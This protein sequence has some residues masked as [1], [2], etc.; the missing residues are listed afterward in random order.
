MSDDSDKTEEPSEHKL[1]EARR[2]GQV[3]KSQDVISTGVLAAA[4]YM[5]LFT[6]DWIYKN[7]V[8]FTRYYWEIIQ[9]PDLAE[10]PL[11]MMM[12]HFCYTVLLC[13]LP[14]LLGVCLMGVVA[15]V[16]QIK[17][18]FT[19]ETMKPTLE[20]INPISGVKKIVAI[21]SVV[22]LLKQ[23]VKIAVIG[24]LCWKAVASDLLKF[25]SAAD[26]PIEV[27]ATF[28]MEIISRCLKY[29]VMGS[30]V[31]AAL[32]YAWQYKQFMKQMR[33]S[34]HDMKEEY[35]ETEGNP[36]V[37]AKIRQMMRQ[38][39]QG[40]MMEE[41]PQ[42]SAIITNPTHMA[43]AI[44][45]KPGEDQV[46]LVVAKGERIKAQQIKVLA[47]DHEI[48][49]IENV[50]LARALFGACKVGQAVPTEMYKAVAEILAYVMKLK[51]KKM[52]KLKNKNKR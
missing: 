44:R 26:Q 13:V 16:F 41:V 23:L 49:I 2:K 5:F 30:V 43:I 14:L 20:K 8:E 37:K 6:G 24:V 50:E 39:A 35:K 7:V 11:T 46:P 9:H 17:L 40:R 1:Q 4:G 51:R 12:A 47:E 38:G 31:L 21:K 10:R 36:H 42:A 25:S 3:L 27:T 52:L 45:Y 19:F 18:L 15:N 28:V 32:D 33:M 34:H 29:V 48:P 22:E